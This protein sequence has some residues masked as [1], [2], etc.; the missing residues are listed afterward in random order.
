MRKFVKI[1]TAAALLLAT[2]L[3]AQAH[4]WYIGWNANTDG[5]VDFYGLSYHNFLSSTQDNF[6]AN[7]AGIVLNGV[8][9]GFDAGSVVDLADCNGL[10]TFT[11]SC[12]ATWNALGLDAGILA[13][14]YSSNIYGKYAVRHM[15]QADLTAASIGTGSNTVSFTTFANNVDWAG[16]NFA[17]AG[18]TT[19]SIN[20]VVN[21]V[22]EP[23]TLAIMGLGLLGFQLRRRN[24]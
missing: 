16:L 6:I 2:S 13:T 11:G 4:V 24:K 22:P 23:S 17:P 9:F 21:N 3:S 7:P 1:L 10:G 19:A 20:V 14:N 12:D 15:S 8:Q 18:V 5:T